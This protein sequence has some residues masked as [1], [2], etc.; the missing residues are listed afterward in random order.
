MQVSWLGCSGVVG[1]SGHMLLDMF[2]DVLVWDGVEGV[3]CWKNEWEVGSSPVA[4]IVKRIA[5]G[6]RTAL[7]VV[8]LCEDIAF[9]LVG[10]RM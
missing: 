9:W 10:V 8:S 1:I 5:V 7:I 4:S 2:K 6:R 3:V